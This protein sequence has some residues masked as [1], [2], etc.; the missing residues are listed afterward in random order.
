M[1]FWEHLNP[2]TLVFVASLLLGTRALLSAAPAI[3]KA[4]LPAAIVAGL[5]GMVL[6]P[7]VLGVIPFDTD[8]LETVVYHC[9]GL[10]YVALTLQAPPKG[11]KLPGARSFTYGVPILILTQGALGLAFIL[12]WNLVGG[13]L[14]PGFG[15]ML[16]LGFSQGPGQALAL[17]SAWEG[18]AQFVNG[19]QAGLLVATLGFVW[20]S[21]VGVALFHIG[22]RLGWA[23]QRAAQ[24]QGLDSLDVTI[25]RPRAIPGDLDHLTGQLAIIGGVYLLTWGALA[26]VSS[27]VP[28]QALV[29]RLWGF[30]FIFALGITLAVRKGLEATGIRERLVDDEVQTRVSGLIIDL[31]A[32]CAIAAVRVDLLVDLLLPAVALAV[33]GGVLTTAAILWL[34]PRVFPN[35][36]FAHMLLLFGTATGTLPTGLVLL[37]L[38]DPDL[39]SDAARNVV[40]GMPGAVLFS[41]PVLLFVVPLPIK[42]FPASYPGSAWLAMGICLGYAALIAVLWRVIGPARGVGSPLSLWPKQR[43]PLAK[44]AA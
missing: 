30:H 6:G 27:L 12:A 1:H 18:S 16:A 5:L 23:K 19:G 40:L 20:C 29:E 21:A 11:V 17:G 2:L 32:V 43:H 14:H 22:R 42:D 28:D 10:L 34:A 24:G 36:P 31:A 25:K 8:T 4:A 15:L 39:A 33:V 7:G 26:G 35:D 44:D 3:K 9:L 37:R 13:D 41:I 38:E